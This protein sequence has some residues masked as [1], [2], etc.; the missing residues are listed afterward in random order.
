MCGSPD[1]AGERFRVVQHRTEFVNPELAAV[2]SHPDLGIKDRTF[3]SQADG[4]GGNRQHG[5]AQ[6]QK[7]QREMKVEQCLD[8]QIPAPSRAN[9]VFLHLLHLFNTLHF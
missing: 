8:G 5:S 4:Q 2:S 9:G 1:R 3:R 6:N 7:Q